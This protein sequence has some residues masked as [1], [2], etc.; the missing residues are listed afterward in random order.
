[1]AYTTN[2]TMLQQM[3]EGKEES[4]TAFREFYKPFI[5]L[6]GNDFKLTSEEIDLLIQDVVL[7][8]FNEHILDNYDKSKG[9]FRGYLRT[10]IKRIALRII[11]KRS[12]SH[13]AISADESEFEAEDD[14]V[15]QEWHAFL[16][17]KALQ[18]L[19]ESMDTLKYMAFEMYVL[20]GND[21]KTVAK[22]LGMTPNQVYLIQSRTKKTLQDIIARLENE[23]G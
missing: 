20:Q 4:W 18:E 3:R 10:V 1:M 12:P 9:R 17:E 14:N 19:K 16:M 7:A 8:C 2:H 22:R 15:E 5:V 11:A 13:V 6:R 21:A 23:L